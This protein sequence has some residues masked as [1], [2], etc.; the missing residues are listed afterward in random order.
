[1]ELLF[2]SFNRANDSANRE[3]YKNCELN[4][5]KKSKNQKRISERNLQ[6]NQQQ[7]SAASIHKTLKKSYRS[8]IGLIQKPNGSMIENKK[9]I[10]SW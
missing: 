9:K 3:V 2:M 7:P 10:C 1:M 6:G 5:A 8:L 4:T